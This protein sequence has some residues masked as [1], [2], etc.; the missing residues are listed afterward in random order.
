M[1]FAVTNPPSKRIWVPYE[2]FESCDLCYQE[3]WTHELVAVTSLSFSVSTIS[4]PIQMA[5][6]PI[7]LNI[8][9]NSGTYSISSSSTTSDV[10]FMLTP[11]SFTN[12]SA[13]KTTKLTLNNLCTEAGFTMITYSVASYGTDPAPSWV[14]VSSSS[15]EITVTPPKVDEDTDYTFAVFADYPGRLG[16]NLKPVTITVVP[17]FPTCDVEGCRN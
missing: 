6:N 10:S 14:T 1:I 15:G 2:V 8:T 12:I 13:T 7:F 11:V 17:Y 16:A 9:Y 4:D 5:G 3:D